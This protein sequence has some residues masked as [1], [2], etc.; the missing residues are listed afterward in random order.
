MN[1]IVLINLK[2]KYKNRLKERLKEHNVKFINSIETVQSDFEDIDIVIGNPGAHVNVN[3]PK[4]QL[5]QLNSA[6]SNEYVKEGLI[7]NSTKLANASGCYGTAIA[8]HTIGMILMLNKNFNAYYKQMLEGYWKPISGGKE[9]YGSTVAIVGLGDL[10][11]ELANRLKAFNTQIIGIKRTLSNIPKNIDEL[12]TID[13]LDE[14]LPRADFIVSCLP[15]TKDTIHLFNKERFLKMKSDAVFVNVGRG[16]AV[17]TI[18]LKEILD[19]GH[20]HG[21]A[22]DV[23]Q[24]EPLNKDDSLWK[25]NN[26]FITPHSSGGYEWDSVNNL[27]LDLVERNIKKLVEGNEIE[28][29]VDRNTGYRKKTSI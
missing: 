4:I 27:F 23:V 21:V 20:L 12:Y 29:V 15:E 24:E 10:G 25:Y 14:V 18:D 17:N 3:N 11:Y 7:N 9:L 2:M 13:K 1:I 22:L 28:N 8:E 26:V 19:E 6:G 5:I 16:S